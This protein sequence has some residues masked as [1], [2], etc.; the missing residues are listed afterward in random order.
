[1]NSKIDLLTLLNLGYLPHLD[2][3]RDSSIARAI[4]IVISIYFLWIAS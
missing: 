2:G 1:M 3:L 4:P